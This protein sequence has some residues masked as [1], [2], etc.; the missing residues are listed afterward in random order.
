MKAEFVVKAECSADYDE[1]FTGEELSSYIKG[2]LRGGG[3]D[4][5]VLVGYL[6]FDGEREVIK[7]ERLRKGRGGNSQ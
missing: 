2:L 7:N 6:S 4:A 5:K 3:I 1:K